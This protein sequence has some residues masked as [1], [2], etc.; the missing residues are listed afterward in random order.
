MYGEAQPARG[1]RAERRA[2]RLRG[3]G[4][5]V[6]LGRQLREFRRERLRRVRAERDDF[7]RA[8][9][10]RLALFGPVFFQHRV[11]VAPAEAEGGQRRPPRVL[12]PRQP[13]PHLGVH[14]K[15][16]IRREQRLHRA[17][18]L[19]RRRQHLEVYRQRR[20]D[21][22]RGAGC[23]LRV[24]D[25]RFHRADRAPGLRLGLRAPLR[26][27]AKRVWCVGVDISERSDFDR[28][29]DL[30]AGAVRFHEFDCVGRHAGELVRREQRLLLPG[31]ARRVDRVALAV[32]AGADA[33]DDR[34]HGV[35]VALGV[36]EAL[37]HHHPQPFAQDGAVAVF[38]EGL[39]VARRR[40]RRRL[41][42]AHVHE[43][44]VERVA[45]AGDRDIAPARLQFE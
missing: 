9:P 10:I 37:Q 21:E 25:L 42:E 12:A 1:G 26:V 40:Q 6:P 36:R 5:R 15:R 17:L 18:H 13:R 23:G 3:A 32:A 43:D 35:A 31:G 20:L 33:L 38:G 28:V 7:D 39:R 41:A 22:R 14:V 2:R 30:R 24:T 4:E 34:V 19:D 45:P 44:V 29:A 16:R 27:A 11:E 8:V